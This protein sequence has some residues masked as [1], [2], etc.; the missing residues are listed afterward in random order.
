MCV[1]ICALIG[2]DL[3]LTLD[4]SLFSAGYIEIKIT[5]M[6]KDGTITTFDLGFTV[7]GQYQRLQ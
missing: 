3:T 7:T 2:S 4:T 1:C 6:D 5:A